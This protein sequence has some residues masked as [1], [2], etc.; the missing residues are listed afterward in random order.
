MDRGVLTTIGGDVPSAIVA[1]PEKGV[2]IAGDCGKTQIT[3]LTIKRKVERAGA[4][5]AA[6]PV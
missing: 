5:G 3:E 6:L 4:R 1:Q 2:R